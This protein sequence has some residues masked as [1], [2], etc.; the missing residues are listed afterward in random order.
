MSQSVLYTEELALGASFNEGDALTGPASYLATDESKPFKEG[1]A[2]TDLSGMLLLVAGGSPTP[3][4]MGATLGGRKLQVGECSFEVSLL[5]DGAIASIPLAART[6]EGEFLIM[7][8]SP[9]ASVL[10]GW[11]DFIAK[12]EQGGI[13][14]YV[15]LA[16]KEMTDRLV[17]LALA[18]PAAQ[19]VLSDYVPKGQ[20]LPKSGQVENLDLDGHITSIVMRPDLPGDPNYLL[21]V[22]PAYARVLWRSLLSFNTVTPVGYQAHL[23]WRGSVLPS[24]SRLDE[25]DRLSMFPA[26]LSHDG[27]IRLEHDFIGARGLFG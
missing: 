19:A 4:F 5:G 8:A 12:V 1:A 15:G 25:L 23:S 3:S 18:G 6:G 7:D 2:L 21:L 14:P 10:G 26:E 27:L 9:R 24:L 20:S 22:P 16:L 11:L 17:P 13:R